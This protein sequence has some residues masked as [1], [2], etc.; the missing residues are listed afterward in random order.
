MAVL[1]GYGTV[2][3]IMFH[4]LGLQPTRSRV[5]MVCRGQS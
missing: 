2:H 4:F 5:I 3:L 1:S